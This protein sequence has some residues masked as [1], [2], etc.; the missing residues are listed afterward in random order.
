MRRLTRNNN[1]NPMDGDVVYSDDPRSEQLYQYRN[2]YYQEINS[3]EEAEEYEQ[4]KTLGMVYSF[5]FEKQTTKE[6]AEVLNEQLRINDVPAR[7]IVGVTVSEITSY[8]EK[9]TVLYYEDF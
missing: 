1:S 9:V 6:L 7:Y 3:Y 8:K 5:E 2:G 4:E